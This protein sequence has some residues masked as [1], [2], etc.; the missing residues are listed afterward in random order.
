MCLLIF[1]M[2]HPKVIVKMLNVKEAILAVAG[3]GYKIVMDYVQVFCYKWALHLEL[4]CWD[5]KSKED[6]G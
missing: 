5:V 3:C 6:I 4:F 2:L 1:A